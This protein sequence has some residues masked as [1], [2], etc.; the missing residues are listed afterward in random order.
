MH[1]CPH[2]GLC[3]DVSACVYVGLKQ[4]TEEQKNP[5]LTILCKEEA[6]DHRQTTEWEELHHSLHGETEEVWNDQAPSSHQ[7]CGE[8]SVGQDG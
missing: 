6:T 3:L 7:H 5:T 4:E 2:V 8:R 1:A